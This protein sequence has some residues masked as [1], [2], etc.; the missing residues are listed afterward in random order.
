MT[1][2]I[3]LMLIAF[4]LFITIPAFLEWLDLLIEVSRVPL[5]VESPPPLLEIAKPIFTRII[6][7]G[8]SI[9]SGV[10]LLVWRTVIGFLRKKSSGHQI[11]I[12]DSSGIVLALAERD[13]AITSN[14]KDL[15]RSSNYDVRTVANLLLDLKT[16]INN[17]NHLPDKLKDKALR[18]IE[19]IS[20]AAKQPSIDK[21]KDTIEVAID[22]LKGIASDL[23]TSLKFVNHFRKLLA[24]IASVLG[25][26]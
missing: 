18:Q 19:T 17:E 26:V 9:A 3:A 16:L 6:I 4:G 24:N 20:A 12:N 25:I 5:D 11:S 23:P 2:F 15:Q 8:I 7:G 21:N 1:Y 14:I 10:G 22:V 13:A